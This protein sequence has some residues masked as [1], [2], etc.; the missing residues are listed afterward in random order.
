MFQKIGVR[1]HMIEEIADI[2]VRLSDE[3][4]NKKNKAD[5]SESIQNQKNMLIHYCLERGWQI[6]G[7]YCDEDYSGA[8][9]NRPGWNQLLKDCHEG[10]INIVVCKTQSRFSRDMEMIEK[11][12]HGKFPEWGIRFIGVVD[13]V[14][15]SIK[16]NKKARQ[17]NGLIN[18]WYLE[19]LSENIRSTLKTKRQ[20]GQFVGS[21]ACYGYLI[22][23]ENKNHLIIDPIAAPVVQRIFNMYLNHMGY[24]SIARTLNFEKV[25]PP[26][27]RKKEL[28]SNYYNANFEK[29][30]HA[31]RWSSAAIYT[32]LRRR[33][34]TGALVQGKKETIS[35]KTNKKRS[36]P[37]EE[38]DIVE[39]THEAIISKE[40]FEKVQEIRLSRGKSQ[41][42]PNGQCYSL[43]KKV[44][45]LECGNT[46]WKMSYKLANGR[47]HYLKCRT[48]KTSSESCM[49]HRTIRLDHLE[50]VILEHINH[51]INQYYNEKEIGEIQIPKKNFSLNLPIATEIKN[52]KKMIQRNNNRLTQMYT[53]K[54]DGVIDVQQFTMFYKKYQNESAEYE[55][56]IKMLQTKLNKLS[57]DDF[58]IDSVS[59]VLK[60][61]RHIDKLTFEIA[62]K[63]IKK[64]SIG[65]LADSYPREVH[66]E[67]KI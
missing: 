19:D 26:C 58:E 13:N 63:F 44:Y 21:F 39:G 34:Y 6:N 27:V 31:F 24:I 38:W 45:C 9:G 1:R 54:L 35:Y 2:Y 60:K 53:D 5:E 7:I 23:P 37:P 59:S 46:M 10:R 28:G 33:E 8:D 42:I 67:W 65:P 56:R 47:Y 3:D 22:N 66:I 55:Y 50:N 41:K 16:G 11:Y 57:E 40:V 61:Y 64:V 49:N 4:R 52:L 36:K 29:R 12:I 15:T 32:I 30:T 51:L 48:T 43:A 17:I 62:D 18:E 14:D 25:P 20:N